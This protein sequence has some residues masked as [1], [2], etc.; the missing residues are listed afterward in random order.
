MLELFVALT[1]LELCI[2]LPLMWRFRKAYASVLLLGSI[3]LL[4][5]L[6]AQDLKLWSVLI[7][8]LGIYRLINLSRLIKGRTQADYLYHSS[9][10]T[11]IGLISTQF[12]VIVCA[13][14]TTELHITSLSLYYLLAAI[15]LCSV[16]VLLASTIR[17]LRKTV[18]PKLTETFAD[19]DLPSLTVAIPARNETEEL[20]A[21]LESLL[22]ST[23]PKLEILVLDDCSQNKRT[24]EI[25][26]GFAHD[27]VRFIAGKTPPDK[28]LAKNYAYQQLSETANGSLLLFCG[29][30]VRFQPD[31][32]RILVEAILQ[33]Q[34]T[35]ISLIPK[36]SL[37]RGWS[38]TELLTQPNRYA[39]EIALP[40]KLFR[41]P[42]V[43]STCWLISRQALQ[44]SGGFAA[45]IRQPVP[46]SYFAHQAASKG[47]G[48]SFLQASEQM[49]ITSS[50]SPE[51][52]LSTAIRTRYPQLHRRLELVILISLIEFAV[53][54]WPAVLLFV[55]LLSSA[56]IL[57]VLA[58]VI[59]CLQ[60]L[61][62][63]KVFSLTYRKFMLRS[64]WLPVPA[65]LYDIWLL[66][67]SMWQYEFSEVNWKGRNVCIPIMRVIPS[68][69][70]V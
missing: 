65:A 56:W 21:C 4:I 67:Y 46:E 51:E 49:A 19:K 28:W 30:D 57:A 5:I 35:M 62:Y 61:V 26:R 34:K 70:K 66:N 68:L 29:V 11:S 15:Q 55:S 31:S 40:R 3:A 44:A 7:A 27:G 47:D 36:N 50:K 18:L 14:I 43:L 32:L 8:I 41:R 52:Q 9:L 12:F 25:I 58:G 38:P 16:F 2:W 1:A 63:S 10:R 59:V 42:P 22:R 64:I 53:F 60:S 33:K 37:P 54:V 13:W 24:P 39:W 17:H 48:Y 45:V 6:M 23:Y 69:P 20:K